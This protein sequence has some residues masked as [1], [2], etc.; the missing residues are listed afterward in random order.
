MKDHS[1]IMSSSSSSSKRAFLYLA[2]SSIHSS[3]RYYR[4][5]VA[6]FSS[7]SNKIQGGNIIERDTRVGVNNKTSWSE[8]SSGSSGNAKAV[9][10]EMV[11]IAK[12]GVVGAVEM[13]LK[14]GEMTKQIAD[15]TWD[16]AKNTA[17]RL[18]DSLSNKHEGET[19][20]RF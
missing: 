13:G 9:V 15:G 11:E 7:A 8:T 19:G 1:S 3:S 17:E 10:E 20:R 12:E 14:V 5:Y 16:A 4:K 18:R 2:N 6:C